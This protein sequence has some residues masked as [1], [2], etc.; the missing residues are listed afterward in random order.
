MGAL[1]V[2]AVSAHEAI[3]GDIYGSLGAYTYTTHKMHHHDFPDPTITT[4]LLA[5]EADIGPHAG[6]EI[7]IMY[8][9]NAMSISEDGK[10]FTER[11]KRMYLTTGYRYWFFEKISLALSFSSSYSMGNPT[12]TQNQFGGDDHPGTSAYDTTEYGFEWSLQFEPFSYNRFSAVIDTRYNISI[13]NKRAED[14][15]HFGVLL[16]LKYF[17]QSRDHKRPPF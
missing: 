15:N 4:P 7:S 8:L 12:T 14:E 2:A 11:L 6:V 17:I 16:A 1:Y 3:D 9:D 13:T 10:S 5:A